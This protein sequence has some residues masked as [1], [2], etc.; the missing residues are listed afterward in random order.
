MEKLRADLRCSRKRL[1]SGSA[2][3]GEHGIDVEVS[4]HV[5]VSQLVV[6]RK[7]KRLQPRSRT[8]RLTIHRQVRVDAQRRISL[9]H[10]RFRPGM[11]VDVVA[12]AP[13][14]VSGK[15]RAAA[16]SLFDSLQS[17]AGKL[18]RQWLRDGALAASTDPLADCS[19][20]FEQTLYPQRG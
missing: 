7:F 15:A 5:E 20:N 17:L 8:M 16:Y 13:Q 10:A 19:D 9:H 2:R 18:D 4:Q 12:V 14:P 3:K 1:R 6:H 11:L